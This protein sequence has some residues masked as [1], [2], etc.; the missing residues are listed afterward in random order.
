MLTLKKRENVKKLRTTISTRLESCIYNARENRKSDV[1]MQVD[2]VVRAIVRSLNSRYNRHKELTVL[3]AG[4][5]AKDTVRALNKEGIPAQNDTAP[6]G[7]Y[8]AVRVDLDS[9]RK[10]AA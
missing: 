9:I 4:H 1:Y 2:R 8:G 3:V 6:P 7:N 5:L 10:R